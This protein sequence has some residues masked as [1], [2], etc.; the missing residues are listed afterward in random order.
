MPLPIWNVRPS[1]RRVL[2]KSSKWLLKLHCKLKRGRG[3]N[4]ICSKRVQLFFST[5][6]KTS[7]KPTTN[8]RNLL[9]QQESMK[10]NNQQQQNLY[11]QQ[12]N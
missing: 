3:P 6:Q 7:T 10:K 11:T 5:I 2:E 4:V 9:L 1:L 8:N 12:N